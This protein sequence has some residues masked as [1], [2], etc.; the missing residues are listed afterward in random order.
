MLSNAT[1]AINPLQTHYHN[2]AGV[3]EKRESANISNLKVI[4][5]TKMSSV[6]VQNRPKSSGA[7]RI[8][9]LGI[10]KELFNATAPIKFIKANL[11]DSV[12]RESLIASTVNRPQGGIPAKHN[13]LGASMRFN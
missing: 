10:S 9:T 1:N 3:D 12:M 11:D 5:S 6:K 2:N 8:Q 4:S 13:L 7:N